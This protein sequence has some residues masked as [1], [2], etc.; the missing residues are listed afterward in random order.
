MFWLAK[1]KGSAL[2]RET[3]GETARIGDV[4]SRLA[5]M[6]PELELELELSWSC[7]ALHVESR[8]TRD[9]EG[10]GGKGRGCLLSGVLSGNFGT[11]ASRV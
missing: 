11:R 10:E 5:E 8:E 2:L 4:G 9:W 1:G 3:N 6:G 7:T